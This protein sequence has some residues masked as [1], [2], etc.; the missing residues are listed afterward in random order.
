MC[1]HA[2]V[3]GLECAE[4]VSASRAAGPKRGCMHVGQDVGPA[5]RGRKTQVF[6]GQQ[7]EGWRESE[8]LAWR[9]GCDGIAL[10]RKPLAIW[11]FSCRTLREKL[12]G[13]AHGAHI[14]AM[15][16]GDG[17]VGNRAFVSGR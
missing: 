10:G 14:I 1:G 13:W 7:E 3:L 2:Y 4:V 17:E 5:C 11:A 6:D 9:G 8:Y 12:M 15:R 16:S